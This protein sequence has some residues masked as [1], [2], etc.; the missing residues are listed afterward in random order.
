MLH[1]PQ[2]EFNDDGNPVKDE[3]EAQQGVDSETENW[4]LGPST[5]SPAISPPPSPEF[6]A[7]EEKTPEDEAEADYLER[8]NLVRTCSE[9]QVIYKSFSEPICDDCLLDELGIVLKNTGPRAWS[10]S[11][12]G[13]PSESSEGERKLKTDAGWLLES[14]VEVSIGSP[15]F[16]FPP[17]PPE[18]EEDDYMVLRRQ[19]SES[20]FQRSQ[21]SEDEDDE[22]TPA[23]G[24]GRR[25]TMSLSRVSLAG[26]AKSVMKRS[27][28]LRRL[29]ER[30]KPAPKHR[31]PSLSDSLPSPSL[32]AASSNLSVNSQ[33]SLPSEASSP[34]DSGW[35]EHLKSD[36]SPVRPR[37]PRIKIR[38]PPTPIKVHKSDV[39]P[40]K[41]NNESQDSRVVPVGAEAS[42]RSSTASLSK[43]VDGTVRPVTI[44]NQVSSPSPQLLPLQQHP[45]SP[46]LSQPRDSPAFKTSPALPQSPTSPPYLSP[47]L[48]SASSKFPKPA[49]NF[50]RLLPSSPNIERS[51][52]AGSCCSSIHS[53]HTATSTISPSPSSPAP[54]FNSPTYPP[55]PEPKH[56]RR[57]TTPTPI[58]APAP[59]HTS[60]TPERVSTPVTNMAPLNSMPSSP[61]T[62]RPN[63]RPN[64]ARN[65]SS[66]LGW[67]SNSSP[68]L[69]YTPS[70]ASPSTPT[71][72]PQSRFSSGSTS[73]SIDS[74]LAPHPAIHPPIRKTLLRAKSMD[75]PRPLRMSQSP[76]LPPINLPKPSTPL[77]PLAVEVEV[78]VSVRNEKRES[79]FGR[80][81]WGLGLSWDREGGITMGGLGN[82]MGVPAKRARSKL[83]KRRGPSG[84]PRSV[85]S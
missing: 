62:P 22:T 38:Q 49:S 60:P 41:T 82:G 69:P 51:P 21:F 66:S 43:R 64:L 42:V 34:R 29:R 76:K 1:S 27:K 35:L 78:E 24:R 63:P 5:S 7:V 19:A 39:G 30:F 48:S 46:P 58:T 9:R 85:T 17:P 53:F 57:N 15:Q 83:R 33:S 65:R 77:S 59:V 23:R 47:P 11:P 61:P 54:D 13:R 4:P 37:V 32:A 72:E 26:S 45:S 20:A 71:P 50:S 31:S 75:L 68:H 16:Q 56:I 84:G 6:I 2:K 81:K 8:L 18:P 52:R 28:S 74:P 14:S 44:V 36:L 3:D 55:D 73:P 10:A 79:G 67:Q 40:Y 70:T 12:R 25:R 80:G